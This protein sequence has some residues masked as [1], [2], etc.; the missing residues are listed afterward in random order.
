MKKMGATYKGGVHPYDGKD[1]SMDKPIKDLLPKGELTFPLM[2]H[3]GKPATPIVSRGDYVLKGQKIGQAEGFISANVISSVSGKVKAVESRL[4]ASGF[5]VK[6][7][8]I[9]NDGEYKTVEGFG[10]KRDPSQLTKEEIRSIIKESGI[11]GLG[12]AAFPTHVKLTPKDDNK[13]DYII[14]NA[15]ECEP[16][17]TNDYRV[18]IEQAQKIIDGLKIILSLFPN[19]KGIIAIEDNKPE[20]IETL[21]KL[22]ADESNIRVHS[23]E[24]KYPQGGERQV[25]YTTTGREINSS[26]L[27]ADVGC[28]V[29][30]VSTVVAIYMAV[31]ENIPL[32][33]K[34]TTVT[35]D[36]IKE[37]QN[38]RVING[39]SM[40][41]VIDAAGGF[42]TEPEKLICGGP[43]MGYAI[44][45]L[46]VPVSKYTSGLL[47][48]T[49]DE[50]AYWEQTA[51]IHCGRCVD[52]CPV[53]IVP[54]QMYKFSSRFDE[55]NFMKI[56]GCEC[57]E[58]G[59]C[60][61]ACP[62]K[63]RL[64]QSFRETKRSIQ[65]KH[66]VNG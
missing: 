20:A 52:V 61:Y 54:Q 36:A 6:S 60:S 35:G 47:C 25:I 5:E 37:P 40:Q 27:P 62:A 17:L 65:R 13:I 56:D 64:T 8:V 43:M 45:N 57:I 53:N 21:N 24:T 22:A 9:E 4:T 30:N 50:N 31:A 48:L 10:E 51:C 58:C 59:C 39:T 34:I 26:L 2:Q 66:S 7:V 42:V 18:L 33:T 38:F 29:N 46:D 14:V 15:T 49:T 32:L 63:I 19:A 1:L 12:G 44:Y 23:L 11:V 28:L 41:E 55:E 3:L 16:Y